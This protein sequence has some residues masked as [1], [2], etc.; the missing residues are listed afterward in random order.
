MKIAVISDIHDNLVNLAKF[1][2]WAKDENNGIE[3]IVCCGDVCNEES[4]ANIAHGF[5]KEIFLVKGNA[6]LYDERVLEKYLNIKYLGLFGHILID[7]IMVGMCHKPELF[8]KVVEG[9]DSIKIVFYGHTHRPDIKTENN[10]SFINPGTLGGINQ[11]ACF[12]VWDTSNKGL[13]LKVLE[14][15]Q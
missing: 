5:E 12:A 10:V 11:P 13:E 8:E 1:L 2:L 3:K 4:L 6:E 14:S 7:G 9:N 15:I